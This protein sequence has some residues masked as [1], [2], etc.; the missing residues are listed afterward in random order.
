MY[1][2]IDSIAANPPIQPLIVRLL[3]VS[4]TNF[5]SEAVELVVLVRRDHPVHRKLLLTFS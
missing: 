5:I 4:F 3:F 2:N 1:E